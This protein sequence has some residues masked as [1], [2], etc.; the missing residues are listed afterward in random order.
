MLC[1]YY[2]TLYKVR[3]YHRIS[4]LKIRE[5]R[6]LIRPQINKPVYIPFHLCM[7]QSKWD[8]T[9]RP[10]ALLNRW[11]E[12]RTWFWRPRTGLQRILIY[13]GPGFLA[14]VWFGSSPLPS[15][16]LT[17]DTQEDW[18]KETTCWWERVEG[19]GGGAKSSESEKTWFSIN[20]SILSCRMYRDSGCRFSAQLLMYGCANG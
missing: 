15:V 5:E 12:T 11:N 19:G 7:E 9:T 17:A 13:I 4:E 1:L 16:S 2:Y 10:L 18:E 20:H 14:V 3:T 8:V 6:F